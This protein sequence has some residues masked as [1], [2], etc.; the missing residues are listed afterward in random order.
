MN[1]T[2]KELMGVYKRSTPISSIYQGL[3]LVW[4]KPSDEPIFNYDDVVFEVDTNYSKI[5]YL[6]ISGASNTNLGKVNWGD[7][8]EED[9]IITSATFS[10]NPMKHTYSDTGKYIITFIPNG[11]AYSIN[12]MDSN[13]SLAFTKVYSFGSKYPTTVNIT[14]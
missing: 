7:D 4:C 6:P 5:V 3:K 11:T 2:S 14:K 9:V 1:G 13:D 12:D 10:R 8:T